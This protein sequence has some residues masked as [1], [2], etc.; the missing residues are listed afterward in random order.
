MNTQGW[1]PLG[2]T[3]LISF[4]SKGPSRVSSSAPQFES[5]NS[6]E[7]RLLCGIQFSHPYVT[8]GKT[9]ALTTWTYVSKEMS[10]LFNM[11][12]RFVIAFPPRSKHLLISWLKSLSAVIL[13]SKK[14]K[15]AT[16]STFPIHSNHWFLFTTLEHRR[17]LPLAPFLY[18]NNSSKVQYHTWPVGDTTNH[19]I[20]KIDS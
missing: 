18:E 12:S 6:L 14:I 20:F 10:L 9:V 16:A 7:L 8:T 2:W 11:L 4:L 17:I 19:M 5:I 1:F 3:G 13:K 15:S